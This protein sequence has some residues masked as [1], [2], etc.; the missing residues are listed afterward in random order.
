[1]S[2][3]VKKF[4]EKAEY[5]LSVAEDLMRQGNAPD[6]ASKILLLHIDEF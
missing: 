2:D 6:A 3:E 1:M 4:I 5:A